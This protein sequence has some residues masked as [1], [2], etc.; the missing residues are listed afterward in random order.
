MNNNKITVFD[1]ILVE[2]KNR[3][4]AET[5]FVVGISGIDSAGKTKFAESFQEF[6]N[7]KDYMT[8]LIKLD[9]FHNPRKIRYLGD[10]QADNYYNKSF[11]INTIVDKLL[12]PMRQASSYS[13]NLVLLD[14]LT[15]EYELEKKYAFDKDTIVIFEGVFLFREE[16]SPYIDLKILLDL[17]FEESVNRARERD[18]PIYG[19]EVINRYQSK[20]LPAQ[21]KYLREFPPERTADII[22]DNLDW[23]NPSVVYIKAET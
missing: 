9:D 18:V 2:I 8:Q 20:Y 7:S 4:Q 23:D 3:K 11:D 6:L 17:P 12:K 19:E 16:L 15:N 1:E 14:L 10:D 21:R 22:I 13:T 5:P